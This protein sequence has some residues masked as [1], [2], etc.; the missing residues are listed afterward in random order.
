LGRLGGQPRVT[1]VSYHHLPTLGMHALNRSAAAR[2][3]F[4]PWGLI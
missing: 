1:G 3:K 4:T 2:N